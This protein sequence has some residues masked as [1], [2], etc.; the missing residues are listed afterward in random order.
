[1]TQFDQNPIGTFGMQEDY[2]LIIGSFLGFHLTQQNLLFS[3]IIS[4]SIFPTSK[5]D[6]MNAFPFFSKTCDRAV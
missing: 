3:L 2:Q 5:S 4:S 6:V 1:L